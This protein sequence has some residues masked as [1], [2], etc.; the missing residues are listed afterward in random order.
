MGKSQFTI[1]TDVERGKVVITSCAVG[2]VTDGNF[3]GYNVRAL[4][5]TGASR[6]ALSERVASKLGLHY[7]GHHNVGLAHGDDVS[8]PLCSG[9]C[10]M[11]CKDL[12]CSVSA[13][14]IIDLTG[15]DFDAIIGMDVISNGTLIMQPSDLGLSFMFTV[16]K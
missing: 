8:V 10:F 1:S 3:D 16:I 14:D 4:W 12:V 2:T 5:D 6:S 15:E 9:A 11:F 13:V 7:L